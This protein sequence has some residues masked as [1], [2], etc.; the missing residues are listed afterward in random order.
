M[1]PDLLEFL[2][3]VKR[4]CGGWDRVAWLIQVNSSR[5][6][7]RIMAGGQLTVSMSLMDKVVTRTGYGDLNDWVW[8]TPEDLQVLGLWK[9][10]L[11]CYGTTRVAG[12]EEWVMTRADLKAKAKVRKQARKEVEKRIAARAQFAWEQ[13]FFWVDE[14]GNRI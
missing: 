13:E 6:L 5:P 14:E 8:F 2:D 7:R 4:G 1:T 10:H 11:L 9:T 12:D 3:G